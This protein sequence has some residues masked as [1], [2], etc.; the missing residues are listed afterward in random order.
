MRQFPL[1]WG[2]MRQ[3]ILASLLIILLMAPLAARQ[4]ARHAA[5]GDPNL[6]DWAP[7]RA[8]H[9]ETYRLKLQFDEP[10]GE[11][12]GDEI[13]TVAPFASGFRTFYL[14]SSELKIESV[15]LLTSGGATT[16]L[17]FRQADPKLWI[18]LDR[19]YERGTSL[20]V[21]IV[22]HGFPRTGLFFVNPNPAYSRWPRE[23]WSQG[24]SEFNHFWFPC[25][26]HP[27]D[28]A[29]SETITT[30]PES[31]SVV[32][33][34]RLVSVTHSHGEATYDW[35]EPIPHSSYLISIAVGPWRKV[36]QRFDN[37]PVD[38]YVPDSVD[39]ATALRAFGST[40]DAMGFYSRL[41]GVDYPYEKYAQTAVHNF[42][43]GGMENI[44][45]TTQTDLALHGE[46]ADAD[47]PSW[48]LMAHELAHQW[49]GDL[50]TTRDWSNLWL[51]EGFATFLANL[52]TQH[53]EGDDAYR[54][55]V[56]QDQ[57]QA[58]AEDD[59]DYSRPIVDRHFTFPEQMFDATTYSKGG[60]VLDM[61]RYVLDGAAVSH[62][63][64]PS[65]PLFRALHAYLLAHRAGNVD[66]HDLMEAL[67]QT[68]GRNL[69][70]FFHEWAFRPGYPRYQVAARYEP[71]R[72]I[73]AVTIRQT[74]AA[75]DL[76][77][78]FDMPIELAFH[79]ANGETQAVTIRDQQREQEF[80]LSLPFAPA[81]MAFD[82]NGHIY[83]ALDYQPPTPE[84]AAQAEDDPAM[85]SRLWATR[86]LARRGAAAEPALAA[87][88]AH[89]AF[90]GVRVAAAAGLGEVGGEAAPGA[91]LA[92]LGQPDS[93]VRAAA[94][95]ALAR[96]AGQAEV[97]AALLRV[98]KSDPSY[99][100]EAAAAAALGASGNPAALDVLRAE[101]A[102][103][104]ELHVW[105]GVV[106]GLAASKDPRAA[107]V[108]MAQAEPGVPE[109]VRI[110]ALRALPAMK[111]SWV[112]PLR[113]QL[114][115]VIA[116][117]LAD[118]FGDTR[119]AGEY[120]AAALRLARFR[121]YLETQAASA[122]EP[123][124]QE[125]AREYLKLFENKN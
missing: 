88:L 93:R 68:T 102:A 84:L 79:G 25:W 13:I 82:P 78:I 103:R 61:L 26:D 109:P 12:F 23:V 31:Q 49:F 123:Q 73:E 89:D 50:V 87:V 71:A 54:F 63:A 42:T 34:G 99:A 4:S 33:N 18:T 1:S 32:S 9:V 19:P 96:Q 38:I 40:P 121:P 85:M 69:D 53:R 29:A 66:T 37:K 86:Q 115:V 116:A 106:R 104:P 83:K 11:V 3:F 74:Q 118:P 111:A 91:L 27:N 20:R 58:R 76:T 117:A 41:F 105:A 57:R 36:S 15:K 122:A 95:R 77:P 8:Y 94:V 90:Y 112:G 119:D 5:F 113:A 97:Y 56:W 48:P 60:A 55:A 114:V 92:A 108:L 17:P 81:W 7:S 110:S 35:V 52:Y 75:D 39:A 120:A 98:L 24:E 43:A 14:D 101:I 16:S 10:K 100:A 64:T 125:N 65:E 72:R 30:V 67:R 28:K 70:W 21:E 46:R 107:A 22:Y 62:P 6:W 44:S 2:K 80:D 47:Y 51:N 59:H 45:A 124:Q